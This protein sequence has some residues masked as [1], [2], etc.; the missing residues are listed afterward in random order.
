MVM[1]VY[2]ILSSVSALSL[3]VESNF[4]VAVKPPVIGPFFLRSDFVEFNSCSTDSTLSCAPLTASYNFSFL[5]SRPLTLFLY[6][7]IKLVVP[8][9][10]DLWASILLSN[11]I[12]LEF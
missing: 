4:V 3:I 6:S 5:V 10:S 12:T 7:F 8:S 2:K 11:C 9:I 1:S